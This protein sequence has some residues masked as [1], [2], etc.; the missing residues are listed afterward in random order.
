MLNSKKHSLLYFVAAIFTFHFINN[1]IVFRKYTY[2]FWLTGS[3]PSALIEKSEIHF[4][5]RNCFIGSSG[6]FWAKCKEFIQIFNGP[7]VKSVMCSFVGSVAQ[8]I[9]G[10]SMLADFLLSTFVLFFIIGYTYLVGKKLY[11]PTIALFSA[12]IVSMYPV[13]FNLARVASIDLY[14]TAL[15]IFMFY[16]LLC[17][18]YL[19][20]T[21]YA[22]VLGISLGIGILIK[23]TILPLMALPLIYYA[24][25]GIISSSADGKRKVMVNLVIIFV[26]SALISSVW[27]FNNLGQIFYKWSFYLSPYKLVSVMGCDTLDCRLSGYEPPSFLSKVFFYINMVNRFSSAFLFIVFILSVVSVFVNKSKKYI[28]FIWLIFIFIF[29]SFH[30]LRQVRYFAPLAPLMAVVTAA[31][32]F[33][34]KRDRQRRIIVLSVVVVSLAN[35]IIATYLS[36]TRKFTTFYNNIFRKYSIIG[37]QFFDVIRLDKM[38]TIAFVA[39]EKRHAGFALMLKHFLYELSIKNRGPIY[40]EDKNPDYVIFN[41][42]RRFLLNMA[43]WSEMARKDYNA[44]AHRDSIRKYSLW[45]AN[46]MIQ[47]VLTQRDFDACVRTMSKFVYLSPSLNLCIEEKLILLEGIKKGFLNFNDIEP[48]L[49][50]YEFNEIRLWS[51]VYNNL[52]VMG[53]ISG[54]TFTDGEFEEMLDRGE[55][56]AAFIT[57]RHEWVYLSRILKDY[58]IAAKGSIEELGLF[59][60][61]LKKNGEIES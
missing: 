16:L 33:S 7:A 42:N 2:L 21:K 26:S 47:K 50:P 55:C 5:I 61:L 27:W 53:L 36:P 14:L 46:E 23:A 30:S 3:G 18:D 4:H 37:Q 41:L 17:S 20:M 49:S 19:F 22:F 28:L 8:A 48:K 52:G 43:A 45:T 35:F 34:I 60:Y 32:V 29:F 11:D 40:I 6:S 15:I 44:R 38:P 57:N 1:I 12:F 9:F 54:F 25:R 39:E 13:V 31:G 10:S 59:F 58:H 51:G 24:Y 56:P